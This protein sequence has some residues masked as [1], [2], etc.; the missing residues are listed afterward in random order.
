[1][2]GVSTDDPPVSDGPDPMDVSVLT[3]SYGYQ[4]FIRDAIE[5]VQ[6]QEGVRI[7]HVVQDAE[8]QDGT[9]DVLREYDGRIR[10]RS[11]P[12]DGQSDALNKALR[13]AN[14]RWVSWLNADEF[15]FPG[16]LAALVRE[17]DRTG[18]DVVYGD[19]VFVDEEARFLRLLPQHPPNGLTLRWFGTYVASCS[20]VFRR[21]TLGQDPWDVLHRVIMDWELYL[22]LH[23]RGAAFRY[24]PYPGGAY[25]V[26]PGQVSTQP[27]RPQEKFEER[28]YR[29]YRTGGPVTRPRLK[30]P[31]GLAL[32]AAQKT[33]AGSYRRQRL[34]EPLGGADLR[35]FD[36]DV[37]RTGWNELIRRCY[38][39]VRTR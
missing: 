19:A 29:R 13:R 15:Y 37:D 39:G 30:K 35:W 24:H 11:E 5:S 33:L 10:W 25:R 20:A 6:Q 16:G 14:G 8:S 36:P 9:V 28:F 2:S 22:R 26:H 7:E 17:G 4:R 31:M 12:D 34:A 1:M 18:A 3:P 38:P 27:D 21:A 32:H 23:D